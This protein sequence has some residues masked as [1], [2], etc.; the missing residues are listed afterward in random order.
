MTMMI[1]MMM[2]P[3][4]FNTHICVYRRGG[5]IQKMGLG[6]G[7]PETDDIYMSKNDPDQR[8]RAGIKRKRTKR[9]E[10]YICS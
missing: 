8:V 9:D 10:I 2:V 5:G 4:C 6:E 3:P 1:M 7:G